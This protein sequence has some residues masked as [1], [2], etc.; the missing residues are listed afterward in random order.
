M[1]VDRPSILWKSRVF[2]DVVKFYFV[3]VD[4]F[5]LLI[6]MCMTHWSV[7]HAK[8]IAATQSVIFSELLSWMLVWLIHKKK[9]K[10]WCKAAKRGRHVLSHVCWLGYLTRKN[11]PRYDLLCV[12]WDVKPY[13]INQL[14]HWLPISYRVEY[15]VASSRAS[16]T[17]WNNLPTDIC[18]ADLFNMYCLSLLRT[19]LL[20]IDLGR[21]L[22]G[23]TNRHIM[24]TY[25][26]VNQKNI[27][28]QFFSLL[29]RSWCYAYRVRSLDQS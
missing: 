6:G 16:P 28:C 26:P 9:Q 22:P 23:P 8:F 13:S 20:L 2:M 19:D 25:W 29:C 17:V 12:W 11:R 18:F 4:T 15:K 14:L 3:C 10:F 1:I 21:V 27:N 5:P 7:R 24:S